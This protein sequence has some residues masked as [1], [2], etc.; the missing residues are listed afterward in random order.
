MNKATPKLATGMKLSSPAAFLGR[1]PLP[2]FQKKEKLKALLTGFVLIYNRDDTY[3][4]QLCSRSRPQDLQQ[5]IRL[6]VEQ[7]RPSTIYKELSNGYADRLFGRI[8]K[9]FGRVHR[10]SGRS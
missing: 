10:S 7:R 3:S 4:R 5:S 8:R 2:L 6:S 9:E 1:V